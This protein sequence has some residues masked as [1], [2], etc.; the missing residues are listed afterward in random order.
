MTTISITEATDMGAAAAEGLREI[1]E[2]SVG[3]RNI[4][5]FAES[6]SP[7][8]WDSLVRAGWVEIADD[9]G[10]DGLTLRDL[11]EVVRVWGGYC[12]PLPLV[13]TLV[14]RRNSVAA[15]EYDG[16]VTLSVPTPQTTAGWGLVPF[17]QRT[18]I[19]VLDSFDGGAVV[20]VP[21]SSE[22]NFAPTLE[23]AEIPWTTPSTDTAARE[24]AVLWA[25]EAAGIARTLVTISV[26]Y[27]RQRQQFGKPIGSFQA[28]K[29]IL[30]DAH[31]CAEQSDTSA[32]WAAADPARAFEVS[33][34]AIEQAVGVAER[35]I[36][37]HGGMGFTWEMG[38]HFYLRH[39]LTLRDLV[40]GLTGSHR[41]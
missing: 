23:A 30:A 5:T 22:A 19:G 18:D 14:A 15:R 6:E 21:E 28:V 8:P 39:L 33:V 32:L 16:P 35:A 34:H 38:L 41:S 11:V 29:H 37:V 17:G 13:V 2:K 4:A 12:V 1:L 3:R 31:I 36:Q 25:A 24:L 40:S 26:E 10:P 27:T 20:P 7:V 9:S